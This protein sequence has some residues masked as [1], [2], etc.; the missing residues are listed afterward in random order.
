MLFWIY[1]TLSLAGSGWIVYCSDVTGFLAGAGLFLLYT[2]LL[3]LAFFVLQVIAFAIVSLTFNADRPPAT[4][5]NF[6]RWM[7]FETI[8]CQCRQQYGCPCIVSS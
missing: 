7:G 5:H 1:L 3:F 6:Y 8:V 2:L 4:I